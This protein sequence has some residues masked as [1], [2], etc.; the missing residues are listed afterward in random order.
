ME[1]LDPYCCRA[2]KD[3]TVSCGTGCTY[4]GDIERPTVQIENTEHSPGPDFDF[5]FHCVVC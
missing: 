4:S 5:I 2:S 3:L 1:G